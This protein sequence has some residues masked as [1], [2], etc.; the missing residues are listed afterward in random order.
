MSDKST[1]VSL[2]D[3]LAAQHSRRALTDQ[4]A[5]DTE[6]RRVADAAAAVTTAELFR[7]QLHRRI[8]RLA[9]LAALQAPPALLATEILTLLD[10][11]EGAYPEELASVRSQRMKIRAKEQL[12]RCVHDACEQPAAPGRDTLG[13]CAEHFKQAEAELP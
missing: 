8:Q 5:D 2:L 13:F 12:G 1:C 10:A 6:Q 4:L 11:A 7:L 9:Q 3:R